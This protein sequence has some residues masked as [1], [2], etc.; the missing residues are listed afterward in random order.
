MDLTPPPILYFFFLQKIRQKNN[1]TMASSMDVDNTIQA[2]TFEKSDKP[3]ENMDDPI[4][5]ESF[6]PTTPTPSPPPTPTDGPSPPPSPPSPPGP[7]GPAPPAPLWN[8]E[9]FLC[10]ITRIHNH[11]STIEKIV[12]GPHFLLIDGIQNLN[13]RGT[14]RWRERV[15]QLL[16]EAKIPL[17]W[18]LRFIPEY[19]EENNDNKQ[20][21]DVVDYPYPVYPHRVRLYLISH[22]VKNKVYYMLNSFFKNEYN[23]IVHMN[24]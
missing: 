1:N 9:D 24:N 12:I 8:Q 7:A 17:Y 16:F 4:D 22:H 18:I 14:T 15:H 11:L 3:I 19:D 6:Q 5:Y 21:E 10:T 23:N 20:P 13:R 2:K